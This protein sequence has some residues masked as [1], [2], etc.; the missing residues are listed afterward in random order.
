M[1]KRT[2]V[3]KNENVVTVYH[4]SY[5][6]EPPHIND[7]GS[8]L[9]GRASFDD[10]VKLAQADSVSRT[11]SAS[12]SDL[13]TA[14][15][16]NG[17]FSGLNSDKW[18]SDEG[19]PFRDSSGVL[20]GATMDKGIHGAD[21]IFTG[22]STTV[23][24]FQDRPFVH[25]YRI[26][27][28]SIGPEVFSDDDVGLSPHGKRGASPVPLRRSEVMQSGVVRQMM[29]GM[30]SS[31]NPNLVFAKKDMGKLGIQFTG[32]RVDPAA[33]EDYSPRSRRSTIP[34]R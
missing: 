10:F 16:R 18:R 21:I 14:E 1:A 15:M 4:R 5:A 3:P 17:Y 34:K 2:T 23:K 27:K 29:N 20:L 33:D 13:A 7:P 30:E 32:T 26:P 28:S 11:G 8:R 31:A 22:D 24:K 25:K 9:K 6:P 12:I 19:N